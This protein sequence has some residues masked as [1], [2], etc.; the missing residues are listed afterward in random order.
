MSERDELH[1]TRRGVLVGVGV[2][3]VGALLAA[4]GQ[5]PTLQR[6]RL[7]KRR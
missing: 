2:T 5:A 3:G 4:C 1:L 7:P 6:P